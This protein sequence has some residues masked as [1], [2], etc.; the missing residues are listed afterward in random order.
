MPPLALVSPSGRLRLSGRAEGH[1]AQDIIGIG[2]PH[3]VFV[4]NGHRP[5]Q[6]IVLFWWASPLHY[7][8]SRFFPQPY[9]LFF[10]KS[11]IVRQM[12]H[13]GISACSKLFKV[14]YHYFR[15]LQVQLK[16]VRI[17]ILKVFLFPYIFPCCHFKEL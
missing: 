10:L 6:A 2:S 4:L 13:K 8:Y 3:A 7:T 11:I 17:S 5:F 9:I 15:T 1:C 16:V 12:P 14:S